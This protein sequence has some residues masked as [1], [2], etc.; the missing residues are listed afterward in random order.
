MLW[1]IAFFNYADRQAIFSVFPLLQREMHLTDIQLGL[2]GSSF[3][4]VYG[5]SAPFAGRVVDRVRRKTAILGGLHAW[6]A[7]CMATALSRNFTHLFAFRAAEGL[8]ETFYFPASMSLVS[9][10]HDKR[11][12]SRALGTHQT[13]VYVGT[14]AGG[15]FAGLI[16]QT[17][18]W[19]WSFVVFGGLGVLLGLVLKRTLIEPK[20]GASDDLETVQELPA[21][22]A[23]KLIW[24]TPTAVILMAAFLCANFVAVV[25]LSWMPKF[26]YDKFHLGLAMAG[27]TATIFVQVASMIGS[28]LGGWLA[29]IMR[30]R[31]A[32]GRMAVQAIGVLAGAPFVVLCGATHSVSGVIVA[33]IA[34]GFCK[35]LYDANIFASMFDVIRPEARGTAAGFMNMVG[36]LG[37]G[38]APVVI[39]WIASRHSLSYAISV[40]AVVYVLAGVLLIAGIVKF[41]RRDA[42]RITLGALCFVA[43]LPGQEMKV[44]SEFQRIDP[45][46]H[47]VAVDRVEHPREILSPAVARN[48]WTSFHL[49]ITI[50]QR[51]PSYLYLQQN[52]EWFKVTVYKEQFVQTSQGWIPDHLTEVKIPCLV[53]LP[54]EVTPIAK[55]NTVTYWMDVWVPANT[56]VERMRMQAVLK[57]GDRW[58]VYPMEVRVTKAVAPRLGLVPQLLAPLTARADAFVRAGSERVETDSIRYRIRRNA[59]QDQALAG[60]L[61]LTLPAP[62]RE[63][64]AEGYLKVRDFLLVE[65]SRSAQGK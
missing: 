30:R 40:T 59:A 27:L 43:L 19:R 58:I 7:I 8:G 10:Y 64:G 54:D 41:A 47:V 44:W 2:L 13:S 37:G 1:W 18:G 36:W 56:P 34:W 61:K 53:M 11:T 57:S 32:G 65:A 14:I 42:A 3:A 17:Y 16:G 51:S 20:R 38:T 22:A 39:A 31:S 25:L 9:D 12:R 26:L 21:A 28:P 55:Q 50:P 48:A 35:G 24:G 29:D 6:S 23:L 46:G 52:P 45:F 5:L 60:M 49:A 62:A 63:S 33:L 15:F 4:W